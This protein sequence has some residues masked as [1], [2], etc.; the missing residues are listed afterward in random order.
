MTTITMNKLAIPAILTATIMVAGM[1]AFMPVEQ[2]STVHTTSSG[3]LVEVTDTDAAWNADENLGVTCTG[4][5]EV[6]QMELEITTGGA[7]SAADNIDFT[8]DGDGVGAGS[9][10]TILDAD[11]FDGNPP[12]DDFAVIDL[13]VIHGPAASSTGGVVY[14]NL[15]AE[16]AANDI[17]AAT[18]TFVVYAIG[19]CTA[20]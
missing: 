4:P 6:I 9:A 8:I 20:L 19:T 3:R 16:N 15:Q 12:S 1:F 2:A 17:E 7:F 18:V 11:M 13:A 14:L 5:F 10:A